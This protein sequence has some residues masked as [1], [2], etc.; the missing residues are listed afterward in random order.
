MQLISRF[1][2]A[3]VRPLASLICA[4]TIALAACSAP[5]PALDIAPATQASRNAVV[6]LVQD[7]S[8]ADGILATDGISNPARRTLIA[9]LV[10][11]ILADLTLFGPEASARPRDVRF[12]VAGDG[13]EDAITSLRAVPLYRT[14]ADALVTG[15]LP[16][17]AVADRVLEARIAAITSNALDQGRDVNGAVLTIV[18][19]GVRQNGQALI[20][21]DG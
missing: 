7:A 18:V 20:I 12:V 5:R 2:N 1:S 3:S 4:V 9:S 6:A 15:A 17:L 14:V 21:W 8:A 11:E 16:R 13:A 19:Q 10:P